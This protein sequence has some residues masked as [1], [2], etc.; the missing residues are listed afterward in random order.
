MQQVWNK[1]ISSWDTSNVTD[2]SGMFDNANSNFNQD[3]GSWDVSNVENMTFMF[4]DGV[5]NKDIGSWIHQ[6]LLTCLR[7]FAYNDEFNQ[8]MVVYLKSY[9]HEIM[10]TDMD[11]NHQVLLILLHV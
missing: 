2:M 1:N 10:L 11:D 4:Y 8:Y 7:M 6:V 5:F 3:I 9:N